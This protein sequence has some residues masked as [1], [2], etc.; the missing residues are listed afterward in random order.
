MSNE[1]NIRD[2]PINR[3]GLYMMYFLLCLSVGF[4]FWIGG[5]KIAVATGSGILS[6]NIYV[7]FATAATEERMAKYLELSGIKPR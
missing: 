2:I 3:S 1:K 6:I 7:S 4:A 5:W